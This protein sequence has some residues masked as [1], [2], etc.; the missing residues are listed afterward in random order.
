[1]NICFSASIVLVIFLMDK[2]IC[3]IFLFVF[4]D[5]HYDQQFYKQVHKR[6]FISTRLVTDCIH[7]G[8]CF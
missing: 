2:M 4:L 8:L 3:L 1:M 6:S 7:L 5:H